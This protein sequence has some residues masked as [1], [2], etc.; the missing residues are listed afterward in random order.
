MIFF[1]LNT[2]TNFILFKYL[3]FNQSSG[4]MNLYYKITD[5]LFESVVVVAF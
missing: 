3:Y 4:F 5:S 2:C 1:Y